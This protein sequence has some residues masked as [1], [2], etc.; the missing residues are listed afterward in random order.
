M[1]TNQTLSWHRCAAKA[2]PKLVLSSSF[3]FLQVMAFSENILKDSVSV[4]KSDSLKAAANQAALDAAALK[5]ENMNTVLEVAGSVVAIVIIVLI[6]WKMS[7]GSGKPAA[8][9]A[10]VQRNPAGETESHQDVMARK[11][12]MA[13]K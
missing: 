1:Q 7:S 4:V 8:R 12:K 2:W 11:M 9:P 6:T 3:L 10:A 13:K 5:K